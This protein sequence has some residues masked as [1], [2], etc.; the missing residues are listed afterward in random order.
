MSSKSKIIEYRCH[1]CKTLLL[2]GVATTNGYNILLE[3]IKPRKKA[4]IKNVSFKALEDFGDIYDPTCSIICNF[5]MDV[6]CGC[7]GN[8]HKNM[9]SESFFKTYRY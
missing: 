7:C 1:N 2:R 3:N 4:I 6:T 5:E 8:S 9:I